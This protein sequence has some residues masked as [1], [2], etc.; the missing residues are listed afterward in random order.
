MAD[1]REKR[2]L[3]TQ[4]GKE[5]KPIES[6][7]TVKSDKSQRSK[8]VVRSLGQF[9]EHSTINFHGAKDELKQIQM[10][11]GL[12]SSEYSDRMN[13]PSRRVIESEN[14]RLEDSISLDKSH[15]SDDRSTH[16]SSH[17]G[18]P[19]ITVDADEQSVVEIE[20]IQCD[21]CKRSFA[22]K[23]YEK[24][25]DSGGQPK[26][27]SMMAKK[28]PVFNAAKASDVNALLLNCYVLL[29]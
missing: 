27:A 9:D 11:R 2:K 5:N 6:T 15:I 19:D 24:H 4:H 3:V 26:C 20:T 16:E 28:R 13:S 10:N 12:N 23:V 21:C 1:R 17:R 8:S 29:F 7:T 25:F 22:P 14:R 18:D